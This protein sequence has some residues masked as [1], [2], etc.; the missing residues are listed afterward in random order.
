MA[1]KKNPV[2]RTSLPPKEGTAQLYISA[3]EAAKSLGI[4]VQSLYAYVS[5]GLVRSILQPG[6][7]HRLYYREDIERAGKRMGGRGGMPDTVEAVLTWGT[8]LFH[9]AITDLR[10]DGPVYR[11]RPAIPLAQSGRTFE[12]VAELL[13]TGM[14]LPQISAW[15]AA[16][17]PAGVAD[18]LAAAVAGLEGVSCLRL[19]ALTTTL[20]AVAGQRRPDFERGTTVGDARQ[21]L[22]LY[23]GALGLLGP[24][25]SFIGAQDAGTP[26]A[27]IFLRAMSG[28]VNRDTLRAINFAFILCADHEMSPATLSAR[29]AAS[30]GAELRAC[31]LAAIGTHSG[32]FLAGGCDGSE[33]LLRAAR[34]AQ[35]MHELM[36]RL[37]RTGER[38]P[39]YNLK[40][41]PQGDPRARSLL[42]LAEGFGPK[43]RRVR[44]LIGSVERDFD[45]RPGLEV[46]LIALAAALDLP[47]RS[48]SAIWAIGRCAGWVAHVIEQRQQA[49]MVRPR[50]RYV[51]PAPH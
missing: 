15:E 48:A 21:L 23:C 20:V 24:K 26:L 33:A 39:G 18:R 41:Y 11:G 10:A 3:T 35:E 14:D 29:V 37:E 43:G 34:S 49:F 36:L 47:P 13:W 38:I 45:L 8:P 27:S 30:S 22:G 42:E 6:S 17:A 4:K 5:R 9:T 2:P 25:P 19:M 28:E 32:M 16:E 50:A 46:G 31:L 40:A 7:R 44:E 51:G 1:T 12:S